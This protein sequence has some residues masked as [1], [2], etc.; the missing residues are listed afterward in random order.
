MKSFHDISIKNKLIFIILVVTVLSTS[1]GLTILALN[2]IQL[3]KDEMV[4][5]GLLEAKLIGDYCVNSL[6][7]KDKS[8][9]EELLAKIRSLP[10]IISG[11]IYDVDGELFAY[12][13]S[14]D[15]DINID[16]LKS[17]SICVFTDDHLEV[18]QA[19]E[20]RSQKYGTIHLCISANVLSEKTY[21]Y[22][23]TIVIL[24]IGLLFMSYYLASYLQSIISKPILKLAEV[25]KEIRED[26]DY[27]IQVERKGS[28]EIAVLYNSFNSM[29]SQIH[30]RKIERDKVVA[31][32]M[33]SE[34]KFRLISEQSLMGILII[35]D[36]V[37]KYA[38]QAVADFAGYTI[39]EYENMAPGE[40]LKI[41]HPNDKEFITEQMIKKQKGDKDIV[42]SH[43]WRLTTK[44]GESKWAESYS[45]T[46]DYQG[47]PADLVTLVDITKLKQSEEA[48][49]ENEEK[50]RLLVD[51]QTDMI[52]KFDTDRRFLFVSPSYCKT[53]GKTPDELLQTDFIELIHKD[54]RE[55]AMKGFNEVF[56]PPYTS[57]IEGRAH[58]VNGVR[59]L[60]WLNTGITDE[61]GNVTKIVA[62]GRD[63]TD[64]K[65]AEDAL[66]AITSRNDAILG[67]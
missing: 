48:L 61:D 65:K 60:A 17:D 20:Y 44:S 9:T 66:K 31:A 19:I 42:V 35:Q 4:N 29:L 30:T 13:G 18:I 52:V 45:K 63:I 54:D 37:I 43:S 23:L 12:Y 49:R 33:E 32:L 36:N 15:P 6:I 59:Y 8:G 41:V 39:E 21:S 38:N 5:S 57:Y 22:L 16:T 10:H 25:A 11:H 28:D 40:F 58:T 64:K 24:I 55:K 51:N 27:R 1:I 53:F 50:Y 46:V 34:S 62:V 67:S 26:T 56:E 14:D 7:F 2:D 47:Q 3:L